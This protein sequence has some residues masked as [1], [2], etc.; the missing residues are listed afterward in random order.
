MHL[1]DGVLSAPLLIVGAVGA[2][3][4]VA[5][6]LADLD[7]DSIPRA[8]LLSAVFFVA[9]L[10]HV[11]VGPAS[12]HLM[13]TGLLGL[14]LGWAAFPAILVG[15]LLQAAFFGF[16]GLTVLG[17]NTLNLALPAVLVGLLARAALGRMV[18]PLRPAAVS[19]IGGLVG[20]LAFGLSALVVA[21]ALALSGGAFLAAAQLVLVAQ[22]PVLLIEA[23]ITAAVLR[24]LLTVRP[25]LVPILEPS[26]GV[27]AERPQEA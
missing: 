20:G 5:R 25:D 13:L 27:S 16:G 15:L 24:L 14:L 7:A 21:G 18:V 23:L 26:A 9:A 19:L 4:G 2:V 6:G 10:V 11:P 3:A 12:A 8:G 22:M 1:V 17:V